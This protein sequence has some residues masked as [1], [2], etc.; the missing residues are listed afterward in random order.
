MQDYLDHL[1]ALIPVVHRPTFIADLK[2]RRDERDP[3]FLALTYCI[4]A[5][6][7]TTMPRKCG[8]Y[9]QLDPGFLYDTPQ[10][11]LQAVKALVQR[12]QAPDYYHHLSIDKWGIAYILG[13]AMVQHGFLTEGKKYHTEAN[14]IATDLGVNRIASYKS[15]DHVEAQLRKRAFWMNLSSQRYKCIFFHP[16]LN[17]DSAA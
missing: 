11:M 1:Y 10:S 6:V 2:N 9:Q 7:T 8:N 16:R 13:L 5:L 17:T 3:V 4:C 14:M 15:L 12:T